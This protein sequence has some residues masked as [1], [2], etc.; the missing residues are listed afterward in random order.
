MGL[1]MLI[2]GH[3]TSANMIALG[4]LA[5]LD[6]PDQLTLL[7][8]SEEPDV[9]ANAVEELMRYLGIIHNG[10]RRIATE[11]I[12]ISGQQIRAGDGVILELGSSN[13]DPAAFPEPEKLDLTRAASH[14]FRLRP[15]SVH[16]TAAG[17][18]G[19]ADRLQDPLPSHSGP[20]GRMPA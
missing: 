8:E 18:C 3:E 17:T 14:G 15:A 9:I 2:A 6:N 5:L 4:T 20:P 1:G 12:E 10:Q 11:D 7:R 16:R 13:W 19:A